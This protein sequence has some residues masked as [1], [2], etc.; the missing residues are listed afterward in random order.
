MHVDSFPGGSD[1]KASA[2][3]AGDLGSIP[4]CGRS[5]GG[6]S[7]NPCQYSCLQDPRDRGVWWA[8]VTTEQL[9]SYLISPAVTQK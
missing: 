7:G 3:N 2:C 5:L 9:S 1:G 8:T 6:G 4:G